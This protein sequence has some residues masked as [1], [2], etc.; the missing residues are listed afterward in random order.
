MKKREKANHTMSYEAGVY[1][2]D[3]GIKRI[4]Q[5]MIIHAALI[6]R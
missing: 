1:K 3:Y 2:I 6:S 5:E 4:Q